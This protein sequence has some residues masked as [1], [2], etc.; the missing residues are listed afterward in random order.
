MIDPLSPTA[1]ATSR[2]CLAAVVLACVWV[3]VLYLG[4]ATGAD[5]LD[6]RLGRGAPT[7]PA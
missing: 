1:G 2:I 6:R 3:A 7:A 4:L 5:A